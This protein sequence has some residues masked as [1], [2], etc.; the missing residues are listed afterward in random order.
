MDPPPTRRSAA[1]RP[2]SG[3]PRSNSVP[4]PSP[5]RAFSSTA[6]NISPPST[7]A[8]KATKPRPPTMPV[9]DTKRKEY[10]VVSLIA[11][12]N[13][14][15]TL[16]EA[17]CEPSGR[18]RRGVVEVDPRAR[19]ALFLLIL[20]PLR[21][22]CCSGGRRF[23]ELHESVLLLVLRRRDVSASS[24]LTTTGGARDE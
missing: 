16:T 12:T 3:G 21:C 4:D 1:T 22:V 15:N 11:R 8:S 14:K 24:T 5:S 10:V 6:F 20:A 23:R 19:Q 18:G 9:E 2:S 7:D 13:I 17:P